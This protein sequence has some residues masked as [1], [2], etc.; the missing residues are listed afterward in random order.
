MK[1]VI[2]LLFVLMGAFITYAQQPT[3]RSSQNK[4]DTIKTKYT[5]PMHPEVMSNKP[6]KCPKCGMELVKVEQVTYTC[7][8]HPEVVSNKPGKCPKCGM[9]LLI[10]KDKKSN[11]KMKM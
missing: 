6:G 5:C 2:I 11:S 7:P 1:K 10:K 3:K 4:A 9:K 8:M